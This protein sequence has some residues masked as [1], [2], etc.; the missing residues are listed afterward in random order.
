MEK[1][2]KKKFTDISPSLYNEQ[3]VEQAAD[4]G[5]GE[6]INSLK[7][8]VPP[9]STRTVDN[10]SKSAWLKILYYGAFEAA[11]NT[12]YE[13]VLDDHMTSIQLCINEWEK[14]VAKIKSTLEKD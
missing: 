5:Y 13:Q 8:L 14:V 1:E 7:V 9:D 11:L 2:L 10:I 12:F 3:W 4:K 6:F